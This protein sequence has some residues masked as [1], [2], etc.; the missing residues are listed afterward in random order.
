VSEAP[1]RVLVVDDH[2]IFREGLIDVFRTAPDIEVVGEAATADAAV[3]ATLTHRPTI[4]VI[5]LFMPGA[6]GERTTDSGL[7]A[8]RLI[9]DKAPDVRVLVVSSYEDG[10]LVRRALHAGAT[11][12]CPKQSTRA[13]ILDSIRIVARGGLVLASPVADALDDLP[14]HGRRRPFTEL[15]DGEYEIVELVAR[16][17][18]NREIAA[19]LSLAPR[20]VANKLTSIYST[21]DVNGRPGLIV[22]A[23]AKGV[24]R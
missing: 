17:L 24:G 21:L 20:T 2:P 15:N 4:V 14:E 16:G 10:D 19:R 23:H 3:E 22:L 7:D 13:E 12:Y 11:G 9:R 6:D 1:H 8:I 18:A 5:D